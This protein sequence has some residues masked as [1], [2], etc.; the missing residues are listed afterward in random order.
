MARGAAPSPPPRGA[1]PSPPPRGACP[2][3]PSPP[4]LRA[5]H[6]LVYH[7]YGLVEQVGGGGEVS[8]CEHAIQEAQEA[9]HPLCRALLCTGEGEHR[10]REDII[11]IE[12]GLALCR[13]LYPIT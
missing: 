2:A 12:D 5:F 9:L 7:E 6:V 1:A 13:A 11:R 4:A 8:L 3:L 10:G